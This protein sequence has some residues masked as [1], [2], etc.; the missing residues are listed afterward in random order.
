MKFHSTKLGEVKKE[1]KDTLT[2]LY[3]IREAQEI[4]NL[5]VEDV[6]GF[7][8]LRQSLNF[9]EELDNQQLT[10]L[11]IYLKQ[12]VHFRPV[13]YILGRTT[14]YN[15]TLIVREG[16][17]IPRPETEELIHWILNEDRLKNLKV[18]DVG[19]G[20]GCIPVVLKHEAPEWNVQACDISPSA[21]E[22]AKLNAKMYHLDIHFTEQDILSDSLTLENAY[23]LII[24]NPPY[25]RNSEC[26][27][28]KEN[29]L[30]F[31]PS[32]AL[33]VDD[34]DPLIFYKRITDLAKQRLKNGGVLFFEINEAFGAECVK[35]LED[36][37]FVNVELRKD[38]HAKDRMLRAVKP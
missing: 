22:V 11:I 17:L 26:K 35:L 18:L 23:D 16:V 34:N 38:I 33:F 9:S 27:H 31:E 3:D 24:S 20:S 19:T 15:L 30:R 8:K 13:Q 21:L 25:V 29:V 4:T 10:Q 6:S 2:K 12:L 1:I 37:G 5:V 32:I 28:I 36:K 7:D 14:F